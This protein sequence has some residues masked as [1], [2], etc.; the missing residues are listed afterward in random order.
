M[1][2]IKPDIH[3]VNAILPWNN[4]DSPYSSVNFLHEAVLV[5][6]R[7]SVESAVKVTLGTIQIHRES[8]RFVNLQLNSINLSP[9][10]NAYIY[11]CV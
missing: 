2:F 7:W 1:S 10:A 9:L 4:T 5:T 6:T 11:M 3:V 8:D